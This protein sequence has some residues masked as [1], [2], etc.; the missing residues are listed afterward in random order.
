MAGIKLSED[1][2][3]AE[4][5]ETPPRNEKLI[6]SGMKKGI[7]EGAKEKAKRVWN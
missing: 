6:K 2:L 7:R 4:G 1:S 5:Q 3:L